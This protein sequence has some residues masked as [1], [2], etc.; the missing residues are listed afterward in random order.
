ML[1]AFALWKNARDSKRAVWGIGLRVF[2]AFDSRVLSVRPVK[3]ELYCRLLVPLD[4]P[5]HKV[6]N[7][8]PAVKLA[9]YT[10]RNGRVPRSNNH[11]GV[12]VLFSRA[13]R[14]TRSR[15]RQF[16]LYPGEPTAAG[17][18]TLKRRKS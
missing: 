8:T 4:A 18:N 16:C 3:T 15:Q 5:F 11:L 17:V 2:S 6:P 7:D 9:A 13:S 12:S 1:L 14:G 10:V